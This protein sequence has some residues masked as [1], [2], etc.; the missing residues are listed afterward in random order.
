MNEE[1]ENFNDED[2]E[3][4]TEL[5]IRATDLE[6]ELFDWRE[7]HART[8]A[9]RAQ[10]QQV[11]PQPVQP[12]PA[13]P[14][15]VQSRPA[16]SRPAQPQ[17]TPPRRTPPRPGRPTYA[18]PAAQQREAL[19]HVIEDEDP[20]PDDDLTTIIRTGTRP[21]WPH[22]GRGGPSA[23]ERTQTLIDR[24]R[25]SASRARMSRSRKIVLGV[26][27]LAVVVAI[28]SV[29]LFRTS[30]SWPPSV[31]TVQSEITTACQN[32]NVASEPGQVN[33]ACGK[34]TSQILWVFA[35]MTSGDNPQFIDAKT[36]RQGLEPI[37]P[38]QGGEVAWSLNLH[39]P[40]NSHDPVDSLQVAARAI[41]NIIGGATLTGANG[42]PV[43]QPG[44]ESDPGNC[45]KYTGSSA[46]VA[47]AGFPSACAQP[48]STATGQA[49]LVADAYKQWVVGASAA[50]AYDV[51]VLFAN[52]NDPG[53]AQV[54]AI[55]KTLPGAA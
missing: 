12:R 24:G 43:V 14:R 39:H 34:T 48:V 49:A 4:L 54:Q 3:W 30:P 15:P 50:A 10:P 16:Q 22:S 31:A 25:R 5:E 41:N 7:A 52:A 21:A 47:R 11:Q 19:H 45:T 17:P 6:N 35:L 26:A 53:N 32:P 33:F 37:T 1:F 42:K 55:L 46:V 29:L 2:E 8:G 9:L 18:P 13:Q 44:L 23:G 40:Y 38:T 28:A 27:G 51:S 20:E 36:G